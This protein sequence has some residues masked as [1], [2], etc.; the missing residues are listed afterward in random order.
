MKPAENDNFDYETA[1]QL[2]FEYEP[3]DEAKQAIRTFFTLEQARK[4]FETAQN[5]LESAIKAMYE[6]DQGWDSVSIML[7]ISESEAKQRYGALVK[8]KSKKSA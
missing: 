3:S 1:S 2:A 5:E 6:F 4:N 8:K 7:G